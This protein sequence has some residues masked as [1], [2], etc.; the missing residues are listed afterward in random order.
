MQKHHKQ[1]SSSALKEQML[2]IASQTLQSAPGNFSYN[3]S[4]LSFIDGRFDTA[5][6]EETRDIVCLICK[7]IGFDSS[8]YGASLNSNDLNLILGQDWPGHAAAYVQQDM[9][10][11]V[12]TLVHRLFLE[13]T[14]I[15]NLQ[16]M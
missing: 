13:N 1:P 3:Q 6:V 9:D 15:A 5:F 2:R 10:S 11:R 16:T 4:L 7:E 12:K 8:G 14:S